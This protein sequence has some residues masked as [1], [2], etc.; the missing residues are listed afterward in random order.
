MP[1]FEVY[2]PYVVVSRVLRGAGGVLKHVD[3]VADGVLGGVVLRATLAEVGVEHGPAP[4]VE[5][6]LSLWG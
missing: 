2:D 3:G 5:T 1:T 6:H 4:L